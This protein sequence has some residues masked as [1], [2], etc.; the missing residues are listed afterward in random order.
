MSPTRYVKFIPGFSFFFP[1]RRWPY[2][3][4]EMSVFSSHRKEALCVIERRQP[5]LCLCLNERWRGDVYC[6]GGTGDLGAGSTQ[7]RGI[8][9]LLDLAAPG[10]C[11]PARP[12]HRA[13]LAWEPRNLPRAPGACSP[14]DISLQRR[15]HRDLNEGSGG[16]CTGRAS[17]SPPGIG[18]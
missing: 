7:S 17:G 6:P 12:N 5:V 11:L 10:S 1:Q 13:D 8:L 4:R 15:R 9:V 14:L 16:R 3:Q 18:G 2:K